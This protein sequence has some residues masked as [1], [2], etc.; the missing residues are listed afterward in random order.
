LRSKPILTV[1]GEVQL[2]RPYYLCAHCHSGQFPIDAELDVVKTSESPG[3]RRRLA[4]VGHAA[5]F[6]HGRRQREVLAGRKATTQAVERT[7][8]A[9]GW[10]ILARQ[11]QDILRA[12]P[13]GLPSVAG[14]RIPIRYIQIDGTGVPVVVAD[15]QGQ[16]GNNPANLHTLARPNSGCVQTA[17]DAD[18]RPVR[19]ESSTTYVGA[20]ETAEEFG[21]R[22]YTEAWRR[23]WDRADLRVLMGDGAVWIWNIGDQHFPDPIQRIIRTLKSP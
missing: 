18:G 14:P 21:L 23:G 15:T 9:I 16:K 7:A 5:P 4:T 6:D 10:D 13:L 2:G 20:I 17:T 1:V 19:D 22:I 3:V 11:Q 8:E 12:K